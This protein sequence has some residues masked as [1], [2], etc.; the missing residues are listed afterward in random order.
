MPT[1]KAE[2]KLVHFSAPIITALWAIQYGVTDFP[3]FSVSDI[4]SLKWHLLC[5]LAFDTWFR[6]DDMQRQAK[7]NLGLTIVCTVTVVH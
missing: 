4:I 6:V 1:A 5:P 2:D 7:K 3:G